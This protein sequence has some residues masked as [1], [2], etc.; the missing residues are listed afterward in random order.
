L[1]TTAR[2]RQPALRNAEASVGTL[3]ASVE[4]LL[5]IPTSSG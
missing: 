4:S 1:L 3:S 2:V 5:T